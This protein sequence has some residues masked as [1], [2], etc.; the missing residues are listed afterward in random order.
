MGP[1]QCRAADSG[2][3]PSKQTKTNR[4]RDQSGGRPATTALYVRCPRRLFCDSKA[5]RHV[6]RT[7]KLR[8][9]YP[10]PYQV[11]RAGERSYRRI[12]EKAV[13]A[14]L[15]HPASQEPSHMQSYYLDLSYSWVETAV[16]RG[17]PSNDLLRV[18]ISRPHERGHMLFAVKAHRESTDS[19]H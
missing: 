14:M 18:V 9:R 7:K 5:G 3:Q 10:S 4:R 17:L 19:F 6:E 16:A 13:G 11:G 15:P 12:T 2:L 1:E 8:T